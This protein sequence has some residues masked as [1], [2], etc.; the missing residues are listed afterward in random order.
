MT[1]S[2]ERI[3]HKPIKLERVDSND[4]QLSGILLDDASNNQIQ[5]FPGQIIQSVN[6]Q[7]LFIHSA[8]Q[9][10]SQ[11][12]Q[13]GSQ[14]NQQL[15]LLQFSSTQPQ[16]I[17]ANG[18]TFIYQP[19]QVGNV[20]VIPQPQQP[21]PMLININGNIMQL[22]TT[23]TNNIP[24]VVTQSAATIPI[25]QVLQQNS[26]MIVPNNTISIQQ[27]IPS[28]LESAK[29][30]PVYVNAKQYHRIMKRRQARAKLEAEGKIPKT[31]QKYLYESRHKHALNRIRGDGG[32]FHSGSLER[33]NMSTI[34]IQ[35]NQQYQNPIIKH[36]YSLA[37]NQSFDST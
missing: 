36:C 29:E 12:I 21:Q 35:Q 37:V 17:Q 6:G 9:D 13:R 2:M 28:T 1:S 11:L 18:Q 19:I 4:N 31:R 7:Q 16:L 14:N 20:Q 24:T 25:E 8:A 33:I 30:E 22:D 23:I 34:E 3:M 15:Q 27:E 26:L 5:V 32:R 10:A